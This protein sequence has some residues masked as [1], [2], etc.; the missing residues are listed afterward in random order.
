M[1]TLT[2]RAAF[3]Q[4]K[5]KHFQECNDV[6]QRYK[7]GTIACVSTG[8]NSASKVVP[9][10]FK[11]LRQVTTLDVIA[12]VLMDAVCINFMYPYGWSQAMK[13][14]QCIAYSAIP[15][16]CSN[17]EILIIDPHVMWVAQSMRS[18]YACSCADVRVPDATCF[19]ETHL[20]SAPPVYCPPSYVHASKRSKP[21]AYSQ[22]SA[23][24]RVCVSM[25]CLSA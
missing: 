14:D 10:E 22:V 17:N 8:L 3:L 2:W 4:K 25:G 20:M 6:T 15:Y 12:W 18:L 21:M 13:D 19:P 16:I 11:D 23:G 7:E 1:V 9:V 24:F 5:P